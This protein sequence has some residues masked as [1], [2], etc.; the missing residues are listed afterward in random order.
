MG[1]RDEWVRRLDRI[2]VVAL[3]LVG[4]GVKR[5][6]GSTKFDSL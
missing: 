2:E 1:G 3:L 5:G 6:E 4:E